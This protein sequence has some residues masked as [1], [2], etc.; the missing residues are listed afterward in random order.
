M[1]A[2]SNTFPI[3]IRVE[4]EIA[5]PEEDE[6]CPCESGETAPG[7]CPRHFDDNEAGL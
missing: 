2:P 7:E 6:A 3:L 1:P 4:A 5:Y